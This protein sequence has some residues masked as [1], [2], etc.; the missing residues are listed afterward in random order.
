LCVDLTSSL[1]WEVSFRAQKWYYP[2]EGDI[3]KVQTFWDL[4]M[5]FRMTTVGKF[6]T[7]TT[8]KTLEYLHLAP[9]GM[10]SVGEALKL[11]ADA[12]VAGGQKKLFTV[13]GSV[14]FSRF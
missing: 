13:G 7:Q 11:A 3:F 10:H 9:K 5:V 12:L 14:M 6:C 1:G 8:L 4:V 2:L